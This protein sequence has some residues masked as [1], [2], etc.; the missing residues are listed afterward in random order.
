MTAA[1][2]TRFDKQSR[3]WLV[4]THHAQYAEHDN[5]VPSAWMDLRYVEQNYGPL[6]DVAPDEQLD[7][8]A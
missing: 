5:A 7:L 4:D 3:R 6:V 8:F 1:L 2:P